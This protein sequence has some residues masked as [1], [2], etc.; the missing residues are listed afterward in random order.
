MKGGGGLYRCLCDV[1]RQSSERDT[2]H[3]CHD[4]GESL[5]VCEI[6]TLPGD[7]RGPFWGDDRRLRRSSNCVLTLQTVADGSV[8]G[9]F[10]SRGLE[11]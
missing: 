7:G 5:H 4:K 3:S 2:V 9:I 11:S 10:P 6:T 1:V 8:P